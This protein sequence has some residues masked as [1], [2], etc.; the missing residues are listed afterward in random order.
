MRGN[1]TTFTASTK[2]WVSGTTA[3]G[4]DVA[5]GLS[6][7]KSGWQVYVQDFTSVDTVRAVQRDR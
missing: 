7:I 4:L 2:L 3:D 6:R 5:L 1:N